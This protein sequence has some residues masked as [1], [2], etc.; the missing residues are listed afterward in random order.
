MTSGAAFAAFAVLLAIVPALDGQSTSP[1]VSPQQALLSNYEEQ[2]ANLKLIIA[3]QNQKIATLD[4]Q[5]IVTQKNNDLLQQIVTQNQ[6]IVTIEKQS[7]ADRD[8]V[9]QQLASGTKDTTVKRLVESIPSIAG[10]IAI[11]LK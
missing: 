8:S 5:L 6:Q 9:I 7:I 10:I 1:P 3:D 2:I 4:Q 11:A